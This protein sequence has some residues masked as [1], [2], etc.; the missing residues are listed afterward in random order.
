MHNC[1]AINNGSYM[2]KGAKVTDNTAYSFMFFG[3]TL[4]F[5][6]NGIISMLGILIGVAGVVIGIQRNREMKRSN[7][8]TER[9]LN[10][11]EN[12]KKETEQEP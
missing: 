1:M 4:S 3:A 5:T 6:M 2:P 7:D 11:A 8:L 9:G 10:E 12:R